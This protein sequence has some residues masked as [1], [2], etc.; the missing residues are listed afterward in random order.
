MYDSFLGNGI[1]NQFEYALKR[2]AASHPG[3][4]RYII[5]R[6]MWDKFKGRKVSGQFDLWCDEILYDFKTAK[7]WKYIFADYE[8]YEI[9]LNLYAYMARLEGIESEELKIIMLMKD[10]QKG[11]AQFVSDKT[12]PSEPIKLIDIPHWGFDKQEAFLM[13]RLDKQI[14]CE[15]VADDELPDC[16]TKE[17]WEKLPQIAIMEPGAARATRCL[18]DQAAVDSYLKWRKDHGKEITKYKLE[19]RPGNR[20]RCAEYCPVNTWCKQWG[21]YLKTKGG[22]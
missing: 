16:T 18:A 1:H 21:D 17:M 2:W 7:T 14:E 11:K 20:L 10:W 13:D 12:Y 3:V 9:Q 5:E 22:K 15:G 19:Q 6:R 8:D 4:R